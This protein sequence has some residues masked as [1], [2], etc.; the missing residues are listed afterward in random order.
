MTT[1]NFIII[2]YRLKLHCLVLPRGSRVAS[3]T[4]LYGMMLHI[5]F[6]VKIYLFRLNKDRVCLFLFHIPYDMVYGIPTIPTWAKVLP[7]LIAPNFIIILY[8]VNLHSL[9]PPRGLR[10][11]SVTVLYSMM[12]RIPYKVEIYLFH[13]I[14]DRVC[15]FLFHIPYDMVYGIPTVPILAKV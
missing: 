10:V 9:V 15:L 5:P 1:P 6:N 4:V 11:A 3:V 8:G 13:L 12:L 14:K 7:I 2:S